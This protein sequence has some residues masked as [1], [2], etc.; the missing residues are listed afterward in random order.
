MRRRG[1]T[2]VEILVV[3]AIVAVM[4]SVTILG[5]G[6]VSSARLKRGSTQV[7]GAVRIAYAHATATSKV[8]RLVFDFEENK[9]VLEE[10]EGMH[11]VRRDQSGGAEAATEIE[12]QA[13]AAAALVTSGPRAGRASFTAVKALGFP[14]EGRELPSGIQFWQIDAD[15]Q[16]QPVG[17]GKAYLYFFPG[18]QTETAAIQ[19]RVSNA[20]EADTGS[21]MTVVVAPLTGKAHI[22]KGRVEM[23][24]PR[25]ETEASER[26][27]VGP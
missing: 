6:G 2:L 10:A 20:D 4:A 21:Y 18:G 16:E 23:P 17:E 9:I 7:S 1:V 14:E 12:E 13:N 11:L 3:I 24:R 15:H 22:H 8:T 25:D 27:D 19:L 26:E 5:F